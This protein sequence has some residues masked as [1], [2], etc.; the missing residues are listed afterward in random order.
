M[1]TLVSLNVD[2]VQK[3]KQ[4]QDLQGEKISQLEKELEARKL[5]EVDQ[6]KRIATLEELIGKLMSETPTTEN[7]T[8]TE[9]P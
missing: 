4:N 3:I 1:Y 8:Q 5:K 7:T 6:E 2:A 9:Q